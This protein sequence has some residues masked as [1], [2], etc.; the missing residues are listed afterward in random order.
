[1][2]RIGA[3]PSSLRK[4]S[5]AV[6]RR[7][8]AGEGYFSPGFK[9]QRFARGLVEGNV[10]A[11]DVAWRGAFDA[12]T[13]SRLFVE[14]IRRQIPAD[15]AE[16][17]LSMRAAEAGADASVWKAWSW[18]YLRTYL[19]DDVMVKVD[20]ATM[21]YGLEA[22]APLLDAE[23]V[24]YLLRLPPTYT[25]GAWRKKRLF[26]EL[27][28]GR[29]PDQVLDRPKHG[30]AIPVAAWLKGPLAERLRDVTS[31]AFLREQ[32]LFSPDLVHRLLQEQGSGRIDR[33]KEL[34]AL[35]SFQL[36]YRRWALK[37]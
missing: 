37:V 27:L 6:L 9:A 20:R 32:G 7:V 17:M 8:P 25:F 36:W 26:K 22:R 2:E 33:R 24:A 10:W 11:R 28:R 23:V 1:M 15:T 35:L 34:W 30:F 21:W 5:A 3:L 14:A 19:M 29:I 12:P 13:A 16:R 31:E 4:V 18:A